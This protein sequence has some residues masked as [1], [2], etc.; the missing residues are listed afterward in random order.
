MS[1]RSR[2]PQPSPASSEARSLARL[3]LESLGLRCLGPIEPDAPQM[4]VALMIGELKYQPEINSIT[5]QIVR[6]AVEVWWSFL[7]ATLVCEAEPMAQLASRLGVPASR[8]VIPIP[9]SRGHTTRKVAE[10][11]Q[12]RAALPKRSSLWLVTHTLHSD[13]ARRIL[14]R[15]GVQATCLGLD[16]PF[17]RRDSDWKLRSDMRF[18]LYNMAAALYCRCRGWL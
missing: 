2:S 3:D 12:A 6:T 17:S 10:W 11:L 8:L 14:E 1:T 5:S 13:R 9:G 18:R 15:G 7:S 16:L 4:I